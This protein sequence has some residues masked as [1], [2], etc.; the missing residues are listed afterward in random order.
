MRLRKP[1]SQKMWMRHPDEP[2]EEAGRFQRTDVGHRGASADGRHVA[3]VAVAK[4]LKRLASHR[5]EDVLRGML[6]TLLGDLRHAGQPVAVLLQRADVADDEDPR[7]T[8]HLAGSARQARA[9][10]DRAARRATAQPA[11]R[12][13]R[14]P[15]APSARRFVRRR[16]FTPSASTSVTTASGPHLDAEPRQRRSALRREATR[17][18]CREHMRAS[19]DEEN[20][21]RLRMDGAEVLPQRLPRDLRKRAGQFDTGRSAADDDE[22]E[23]P[24]LRCGDRSRVPPPRTRAAPAAGSRAHRRAS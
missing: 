7:V 9:R 24:A 15:T 19:L 5:A 1:I 21:R 11:T 20:A 22:R 2:R 14:P 17:G 18:K 6:A 12:P 10:R 4:R 3:V 23:Q 8:G 16:I 13:R